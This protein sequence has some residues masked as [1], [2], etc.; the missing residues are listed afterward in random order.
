MPPKGITRRSAGAKAPHKALPA[1]T[2]CK[3]I[4]SPSPS[5]S[6]SGEYGSEKT[7]AASARKRAFSEVEGSGD[8]N[9]EEEEDFEEDVHEDD[10]DDDEK[11]DR[12]SDSE[13]WDGHRLRT[14]RKAP[15]LREEARHMKKAKNMEVK[16]EKKDEDSIN[17]HAPPAR[18]EQNTHHPLEVQSPTLS[19]FTSVL[20]LLDVL[21]AYMNFQ[22]SLAKLS[23][24]RLEEAQEAQMLVVDEIEK[25]KVQARM[26]E[27]YEEDVRRYRARMEG[28]EM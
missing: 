24:E 8:S 23:G 19:S 3:V 16:I 6:K 2:V 18:K 17:E 11:T 22:I 5:L 13:I 7:S 14:R 10:T 25:L 9:S 27:D 21:P 1:T 26:R 20:S 28:R 12:G 4:P 15:T